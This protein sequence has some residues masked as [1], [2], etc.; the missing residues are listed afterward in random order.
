MKKG[1][2]LQSHQSCWPNIQVVQ[3]SHMD[4]FCQIEKETKHPIFMI[5]IFKSPPDFYVHNQ[6]LQTL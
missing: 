5:K 6:I 3:N 2:L 4:R 1:Y